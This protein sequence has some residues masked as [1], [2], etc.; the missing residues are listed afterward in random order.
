MTTSKNI[1]DY[2][3]LTSN[4]RLLVSI[5]DK[6]D[7][8]EMRDLYFYSFSLSWEHIFLTTKKKNIYKIHIERVN[9]YWYVLSLYDKYLFFWH[10]RYL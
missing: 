6:S 9:A 10:L 5:V 7:A 8:N 1:C 2:Y 4:N 3:L